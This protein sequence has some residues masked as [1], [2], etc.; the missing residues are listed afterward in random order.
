M[1]EHLICEVEF[2]LIGVKSSASS[3]I[4]QFLVTVTSVNDVTEFLYLFSYVF[5]CCHYI[6]AAF[7]ICIWYLYLFFNA[8]ITELE[9]ALD[10]SSIVFKT[11]IT[12]LDVST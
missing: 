12:L 7:T 8:F 9:L 1:P 5:S 11:P 4:R 3:L 6:K 10:I 2:L